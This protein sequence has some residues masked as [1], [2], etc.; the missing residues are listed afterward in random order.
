MH[1]VGANNTDKVIAAMNKANSQQG[2]SDTILSSLGTAAAMVL[3]S[4]NFFY[5][6]R[7]KVRARPRGAPVPPAATRPVAACAEPRRVGFAGPQA[8][9]PAQRRRVEEPRRAVAQAGGDHPD[10]DAR[11]ATHLSPLTGRC[12]RG[13]EVSRDCAAVVDTPAELPPGYASWLPELYTKTDDEVC[14]GDSPRALLSFAT[15]HTTLSRE[16]PRRTV[17]IAARESPGWFSPPISEQLPRRGATSPPL[18]SPMAAEGCLATR[19]VI[20]LGNA[21]RHQRAGWS[22]RD[23]LGI[24]AQVRTQ[25]GYDALVMTRYFALGV[26][27]CVLCAFPCKM[28]HDFPYVTRVQRG[29]SSGLTRDSRVVFSAGG[30]VLMFTYVYA[31]GDRWDCEHF[32][33]ANMPDGSPML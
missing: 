16:I 33:L 1:A 7:S 15:G 27:F 11:C 24:C 13:A 3:F 8:D 25:A 18:Q 22:E 29:C 6:V 2:N 5:F 12:V 28:T 14:A 10:A 19:R 17:I 23:S 20:Q 30:F 31:G 21:Q 4:F 9:G 32:S 26:K